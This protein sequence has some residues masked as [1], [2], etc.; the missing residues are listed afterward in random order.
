[1]EVWGHL[2]SGTSKLLRICVNPLWKLSA[3]RIERLCPCTAELPTVM[4]SASSS[5]KC[6]SLICHKASSAARWGARCRTSRTWEVCI[7]YKCCGSVTPSV[8]ALCFYTCSE[9]SSATINA[10]SSHHPA[11]PVM[12][13]PLQLP[14]MLAALP[15]P[16]VCAHGWGETAEVGG[17]PG[18][19]GH[20]A[21]LLR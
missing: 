5:A 21:A 4:P 18:C 20:V 10:D 13:R 1:M 8:C 12:Q 7:A 3:P 16:A 9:C 17:C 15:Q 11:P 14:W 6:S 19:P 2:R